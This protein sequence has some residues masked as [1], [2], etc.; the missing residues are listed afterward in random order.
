MVGFLV[1]VVE[2]EG[3]AVGEANFLRCEIFGV[4]REGEDFVVG[5]G[6]RGGA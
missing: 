1:G 6:G 5:L 4:G 2:E 3:T